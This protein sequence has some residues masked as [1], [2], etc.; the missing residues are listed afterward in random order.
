MWESDEGYRHLQSSYRLIP[1]MVASWFLSENKNWKLPF[2]SWPVIFFY[3]FSKSGVNPNITFPLPFHVVVIAQYF[4]L[5]GSWVTTEK[6][7]AYANFQAFLINLLYSQ[8]S[9]TFQTLSHN[10]LTFYCRKSWFLPMPH[11]AC[12][13]F[14][15]F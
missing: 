15:K 11:N 2:E 5:E 13:F 1:L 9:Y 4:L 7:E 12:L 6:I 14:S 3:F 8:R 10:M